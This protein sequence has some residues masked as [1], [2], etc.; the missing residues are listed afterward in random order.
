MNKLKNSKIILVL[1]ILL[2]F[3]V[4]GS[5][6][7]V[8]ETGN[9]TISTPENNGVDT[10]SQSMDSVD[11]GVSASESSDDLVANDTSN[12]KLLGLSNDDVLSAGLTSGNNI[13]GAKNT[14][15]FT[16]LQELINSHANS[17]LILDRNYT[18]NPTS[19]SALKNGM[20]ITGDIIIDGK[21]FTI[22][23]ANKAKIFYIFNKNPSGNFTFNNINFKNGYS[24]SYAPIYFNHINAIYINNCSFDSCTQSDAE[25]GALFIYYVG[26][27]DIFI[28]NSNFT[29][30]VAARSG[31]ALFISNYF[32]SDG[33]DSGGYIENCRFIN[34]HGGLT[35]TLSNGGA[36]EF[37]TAHGIVKNCI[38]IGNNISNSGGAVTLGNACPDNQLINCTFI[39]NHCLR[40]GGQGGAVASRTIDSEN[41]KVINCTFEDNSATYGGAIYFKA[42]DAVINNCNFTTSSANSGGAIYFD[43][44]DS[45]ILY[46][47][48]TNSIATQ[49]GGAV[50]FNGERCNMSYCNFTYSS[51]NEGGAVKF[52]GKNSYMGYCTY[53][54]NTA[55]KDGGA[56]ILSGG[57]LSMS[58]NNFTY[59]KADVDGGA[60]YLE[61]GVLNEAKDNDFWHNRANN[62][63]G[64]LYT[65]IPVVIDG[66][67]FFNNTAIN[68]SAIYVTKDNTLSVNNVVL[69]GNTYTDLVNLDAS[70]NF[71]SIY[72]NNPVSKGLFKYSGLDLGELQDVWD[73]T[74]HLSVIYV[75]NTGTSSTAGSS[76]ETATSLDNA[77]D[78]LIDGGK[79]IFTTDYTVE[80]MVNLTNRNLTLTSNN[81]S[82][83]IRKGSDGKYLF[84]LAIFEDHFKISVMLFFCRYSL[85]LILSCLI[86]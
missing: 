66:G 70:A 82:S 43:A 47:N 32:P 57:S 52:N 10:L 42:S 13:L 35:G 63:G 45:S 73:G 72:L 21:G 31:G 85:S 38:F 39:N 68:G 24:S 11:D 53:I 28:K 8:D 64:A 84:I 27:N 62:N 17:E 69:R 4:M 67:V 14:G 74:Y 80:D 25:G 34:N 30:N 37:L 29:N 60:V 54:N 22:D 61:S 9:E 33:I 3:L 78:H 77:L 2:V 71:G 12:N 83:I 76:P 81:S 16:Q 6:S 65:N 15:T 1:S 51:A 55:T 86:L 40:N 50:Y 41:I 23:G 79:I 59:N 44:A 49:N 58:G 56:L 19:D 5:A 18:Y 48:F 46:C 7:A 20:K 36:I 26:S 75:N